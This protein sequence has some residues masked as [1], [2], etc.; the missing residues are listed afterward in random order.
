MHCHRE[1][2]FAFSVCGRSKTMSSNKLGGN[3]D[4]NNVW[5]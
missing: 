2:G 1:G 3:G 5:Q 4:E